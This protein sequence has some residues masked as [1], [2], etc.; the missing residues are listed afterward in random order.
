LTN[1]HLKIF[2]VC[3]SLLIVTFGVFYFYNAYKVKP[4]KYALNGFLTEI[5][6]GNVE[7]AEAFLESSTELEALNSDLNDVRYKDLTE[8]ILSK[9]EY[10]IGRIS[11][12]GSEASAD[13]YMET[14]DLF[15]FYNKYCSAL[16]PFIEM[17]ITGTA[18]ERYLATEKAVSFL[19]NVIPQDA[20][21]DS[22]M[23]KGTVKI[24][25]MQKDGK[26]TVRDD[27]SLINKLSGN[28][29]LFFGKIF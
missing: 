11:V 4:V 9:T 18:G 19:M 28:M 23:S 29:T 21:S 17:S 16:N 7:G 10:K 8:L 1:K 25:L 27:E 2:A 15:C 22:V 26:W 3:V 13:V 20:G 5:K 6:N 24:D 14:V 12:N